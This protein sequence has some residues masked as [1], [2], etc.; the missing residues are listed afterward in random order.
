MA[1]DSAIQWEIRSTGASGNGGGFKSGATGTDRSQSD[2]A[3]V[4]IDGATITCLVHSTTTQLN[5]TGYTVID[6]DVGNIVQNVSGTATT[7]FYEITAVDTGN[8][9]WTVDRSA[10]TDTQTFVGAMGGALDHPGRISTVVVD[11]NT[12]WIKGGVSYL[13]LD[14][15]AYVL[16]T[17]VAVGNGKTITWYGYTGSR[18]KATGTDRPTFDA[19]GETNALVVDSI[20][21]IFHNIIF[22]GA[23]GTGV[24]FASTTGFV[25]VNCRCTAN[26]T[27]GAGGSGGGGRWIECEWDTNSDAGFNVGSSS[28]VRCY[29]GYSHDNTAEG[30][31]GVNGSVF[32]NNIAE[33]TTIYALKAFSSII[34]RV[35]IV[36][37]N[38]TA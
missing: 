19:N 8:N 37:A 24:A 38:S 3:Q 26:G 18:A 7:G 15:N 32:V 22:S 11:E 20:G 4:A 29:Y 14:T 34:V 10:G 16:N 33:N 2:T 5:I 23:A 30:F 17:A 28:T 9:R 13:P 27:D 25:M 21:N 12:V 6:G 31:Q 1:L 35:P 36:T